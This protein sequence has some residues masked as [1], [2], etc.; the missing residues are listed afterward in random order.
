MNTYFRCLTI[1][2]LVLSGCEVPAGQTTGSDGAARRDTVAVALGTP[3]GIIDWNHRQSRLRV[4]GWSFEF[5]EGEGP[6]LCVARGQRHVGSVEL[7]RLHI[8]RHTAIME[9]LRRGGSEREALEAAAAAFT[10]AL[11]ADRTSG[12]GEGY[13]LTA[14][15][16]TQATVMGKPGLHLILEGGYPQRRTERIVQYHAIHRDTLYLLAA[17]GIDGGG[18]GEFSIADLEDFERVFAVVAAASRVDE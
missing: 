14:P 16:P 6:F 18:L 4:P 9:V 11:A 8:E 13:Q 10:A 17:T 5:C 1:A 7:L 2:L 12:F 15:P 3:S